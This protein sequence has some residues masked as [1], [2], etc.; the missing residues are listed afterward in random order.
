MTVLLCSQP[1]GISPSE[2]MVK[3]CAEE[4]SIPEPLARKAVP[5]GSVSYAQLQVGCVTYCHTLQPPA[6]VLTNM[7]CSRRCS[8]HED[9]VLIE[10]QCSLRCSAHEDA[11]L[12][13]MQCF[14]RGATESGG[15]CS[16]EQGVKRDCLFC[17]DLRLPPDFQPTPGVS[18]SPMKPLPCKH[19]TLC[20]E[21]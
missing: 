19:P 20:F 12:M 14:Q 2:N 5:V 1:Q 8:A 6:A 10:M 18:L 9:G 11:V 4:A 21:F 16:Q 17:Y 15:A 7:L 13:K 3:E